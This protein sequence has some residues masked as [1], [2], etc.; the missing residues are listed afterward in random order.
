M[1]VYMYLIA[2]LL[3]FDDSKL[4][5]GSEKNNEP[6]SFLNL[7]IT[8]DLSTGVRMARPQPIL[9]IDCGKTSCSK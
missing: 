3:I 9:V 4:V 2:E 7:Y 6:V 5:A 8:I 1:L